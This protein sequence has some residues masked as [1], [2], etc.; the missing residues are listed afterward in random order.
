MNILTVREFNALHSIMYK[1]SRQKISKETKHLN[2]TVDQM[3]LTD[4]YRTFHTTT[5]K[6]TF[7]SSLSIFKIKIMQSIFSY[8]SGVKLENL[9]LYG[10]SYTLE[11][12][13]GSKKKSK[14]K[15]ENKLWQKKKQ[16]IKNDGLWKKQY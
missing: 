1:A 8:H 13:T 11:H 5:I 15:L 3:E 6:Y 9:Q 14:R 4:I 16:H 7:F 2:N 10:N 12:P